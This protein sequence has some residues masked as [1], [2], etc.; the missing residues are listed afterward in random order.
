MLT[1]IGGKK[2]ITN[3]NEAGNY[4]VGMGAKKTGTPLW[5][6]KASGHAVE[7]KNLRPRLDEKSEQQMLRAGWK[8]Y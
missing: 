5:V 3:R 7:W 8:S 2:W 1:G 6:T 4:L